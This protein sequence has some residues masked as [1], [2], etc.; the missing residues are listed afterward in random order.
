MKA[1]ARSAL[2]R[3]RPGV[4][5]NCLAVPGLLSY[6]AIGVEKP[7]QRPL[8]QPF[9]AVAP[10]VRTPLARLLH[11]IPSETR[12]SQ[13]IAPS[14]RGRR[15]L[16]TSCPGCGALTQTREPAE[17]GFYTL[18][19]GS[20]KAFVRN[21]GDSS[22]HLK[23]KTLYDSAVDSL[24]TEL[25][26][27]LGLARGPTPSGA[28][29]KH[30]IAGSEAADAEAVA[31]SNPRSPV[32]DRCHGLVNH[33][34]GLPIAH[35]SLQ[36]IQ[37]TISESPH[38]YNHVYH[39]IDAADFP[40]S[41]IPDLHR[42]LSIARPRSQNRRSKSG[43]YYHGRLVEMSFVI[44]RADLW[45]AHK[46]QVD[47]LMP[48][49]T[50][51]LRDALGSLGDNIRLGNV[52]CVSSKRGWWTKQLKEDIWDRGGGGWMVGKANVGKSSLFE[53]IF[54]KGRNDALRMPVL[55][56]A[57]GGLSAVERHDVTTLDINE[58]DVQGREGRRAESEDT[59][60]SQ[61]VDTSWLLPPVQP[62]T[63]YPVMPIISSLPGTTA[64]PIRLP[65]GGGKGELIDLPGLARGDLA[66]YVQ[67]E[68]QSSLVLQTRIK[69]EQQVIKPNQSLLLGG[70]IRITP[71]TSDLMFISYS[72]MPLEAHVTS[73]EKAM[74]LQ[75]Q[76][77]N[78]GVSVITAPGMG[79]SMKSAGTFKLKWDVT[80]QRS[81][82]L[83]RHA[84]AALTVQQLPYRVFSTDILVEGCG[85]VELV[86]QVRKRVIERQLSQSSSTELTRSEDNLEPQ[87][88][89]VFP[90]VDVISPEG[91]FISQRR[92]LGA[93]LLAG[94][95]HVSAGRE[96]G[97]P[98]RSMKG[99]KSSAKQFSC[100]TKA[101]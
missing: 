49:V 7:Y 59:V 34:I 31:E 42:H 12:S 61:P 96:R 4:E 32:C 67:V 52:R 54:P 71:R 10:I 21:A 74:S 27:E 69:P 1:Y 6:A 93:S 100:R 24:P 2:T 62:E 19:R 28:Q 82:P 15:A 95:K 45:A 20:V 30:R 23:E 57:A 66:R 78:T 92:P 36:S 88:R 25:Q 39:V 79:S 18:T 47:A 65:F 80:R 46:E 16:P 48:Q 75:A 14:D 9:P 44:T 22:R 89:E 81:G 86:A 83:T 40:M 38:K 63:T 5:A 99:A 73:T 55:R 3:K 97:R 58:T 72:F 37:D 68:H 51:T 43:K 26:K 29:Q 56:G 35:P 90:E 84:A 11:A 33:R 53:C 13:D 64:S 17:A 8:Q 41:V 76:P 70:L 77:R 94:E 50:Q 85:W 101:A 87:A 91:R 60:P 98:R